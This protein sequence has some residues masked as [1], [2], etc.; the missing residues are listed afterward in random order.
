VRVLGVTLRAD[1]DGAVEVG[2]HQG[3]EQFGA[4]SPP[5]GVQAL[6]QPALEFIWTHA[7]RLVRHTQLGADRLQ[8]KAGHE[9]AYPDRRSPRLVQTIP[10][11]WQLQVLVVGV[12]QPAS[13]SRLHSS[14]L[15]GDH[16]RHHNDRPAMSATN[17]ARVHHPQVSTNPLLAASRAESFVPDSSQRWSASPQSRC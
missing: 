13:H 7:W 15:R 10:D 9:K 1:R 17:P 11:S 8:P 2:K 12:L 4:G 6:L 3:A 14:F 16:C 5:E